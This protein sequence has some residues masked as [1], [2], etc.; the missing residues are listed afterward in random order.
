MQQ[1]PDLVRD[2][3]QTLQSAAL[4]SENLQPIPINPQHQFEINAILH[5]WTSINSA[6]ANMIRSNVMVAAMFIKYLMS[7]KL[8]LPNSVDKF[9]AA[10]C[11][12]ASQ[13]RPSWQKPK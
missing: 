12:D 5:L 6:H 11:G 7:R 10:V 8:D 9:Y 1:W 4:T 2:A 3:I 13:V